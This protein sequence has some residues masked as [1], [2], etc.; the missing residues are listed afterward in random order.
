MLHAQP[1]FEPGSARQ[2]EA[3]QYP[4]VPSKNDGDRAG[5]YGHSQAAAYP[6]LDAKRAF[7]GREYL[8]PRK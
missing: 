6:F 8:V 7:H 5:E 4:G 2:R 1:L 3:A